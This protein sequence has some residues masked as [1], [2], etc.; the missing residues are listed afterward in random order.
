MPHVNIKYFPVALTADEE[1]AFVATITD[2]ISGTFGVDP[3]VVSIALEPVDPAEWG[4][5]VYTPEI[6][7]RRHLLCKAPN[8]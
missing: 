5:Q 3:G 2:T 1:A 8:Y 6:V 4:E 7:D